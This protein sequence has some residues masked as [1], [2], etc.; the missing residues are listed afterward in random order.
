M[1]CLTAPGPH[2]MC[3]DPA[4]ISLFD[5]HSHFVVHLQAKYNQ[6]LRLRLL[7]CRENLSALP[8]LAVVLSSSSL[9]E[10][11]GSSASKIG[12]QFARQF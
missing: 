10:R 5:L 6:Y 2:I 1:E 7:L 4:L 12:P 9:G 3:S 11:C 8:C